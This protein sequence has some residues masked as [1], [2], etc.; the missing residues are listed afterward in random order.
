MT[1]RERIMPDNQHEHHEI[2]EETPTTVITVLVV[3]D[4][5]DIGE[6]IAQTLQLET[7]YQVFLATSGVQALEQAKSIKP[8]LLL[9]DYMLPGINGIELYDQLRSITGFEHIPAIMMSANL[10]TR[11]THK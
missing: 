1:E 8:N 6:F 2:S 7:P 3:E 10:P 9:L 5:E 4:D 11:E